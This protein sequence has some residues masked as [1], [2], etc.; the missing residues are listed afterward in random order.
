MVDEEDQYGNIVTTDNSTVLTASL[1]QRVAA[2]SIGT[3]TATVVNGVASFNDLEDDK[4]GTS[5][6]P[7]RR[8]RPAGRDLETRVVVSGPGDQDHH[9]ATRRRD[10]GQVIHRRG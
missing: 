6:A 3:T 10:L 8:A 4:A 9:P 1:S 5:L 2:R 7:V